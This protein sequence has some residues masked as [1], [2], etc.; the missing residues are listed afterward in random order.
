[1]P[2]R[3]KIAKPGGQGFGEQIDDPAVHAKAKGG[4]TQWCQ[5]DVVTRKI[6]SLESVHFLEVT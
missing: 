3:A 1:M 2:G 4:L 6:H 5:W